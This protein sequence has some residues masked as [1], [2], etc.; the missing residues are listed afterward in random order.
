MTSREASGQRSETVRRAN[1][2]TILQELHLHGPM[3]RSE[4]V[5]RTGLTRS[6]IRGLVNELAAGGLVTEERSASV[7]VPGR[8]SPLSRPRHDRHVVLALEIAVDSLA[9]AVVGLGGHVLE[10]TRVDRARGHLD[11]ERLVGDLARL[12]KP[13]LARRAEQA[14]L[15]GIGLSM[16]GVVRAS[17]GMI[18][19]APNLGW[20]DVPIAEIV[21][22]TLR[23]DVPM[24]VANDADLGVLAEHRRGAARGVGD[25]LYV[26]GEVGVGGGLMVAGRRLEGAGGYAGE[27]GHIRVNPSGSECR[28]GAIGC[29]ETE[30]GERALL[31]RAG[32]RPTGG[33]AAVDE[34]FREAA[35]GSPVALD[36]LSAT[37]EWLGI[38]LAGLVN[39]FNPSLVVLGSMFGRMHSYISAQI[40]R[41]LDRD[42]MAAP[43]EMIRVVPAALGADAPLLGAPELAFEPLLVDPAGWLA[44]RP[45]LV[46]VAGA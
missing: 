31:R 39:V 44:P 4:L 28:C 18:R 25:I 20:H 3:S 23:L 33:R 36:A 45:A 37:G 8:P 35:G 30:V 34:V 43:R 7:G 15:V 27:I 22:R 14:T 11:A 13:L 26:A 19:V 12:A 1:L 29:W 32:R 5:G 10:R 21:A 41:A 42:A 16:V 24:S 40:E 17:D 2:S 6:A 9:A 46:R 38:G